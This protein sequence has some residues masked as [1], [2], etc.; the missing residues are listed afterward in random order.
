MRDHNDKLRLD[1]LTPVDT[2]MVN[3]P[4]TIRTFLDWR[5]SCVGCPVGRIHTVADACAEHGVVLALFLAALENDVG[6]AE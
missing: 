2:V 5:M 6:S 4:W 1:D 3:W